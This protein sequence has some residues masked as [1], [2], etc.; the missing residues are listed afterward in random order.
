MAPNSTDGSFRPNA[1]Y[2]AMIV[3]NADMMMLPL[4]NPPLAWR[5]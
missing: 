3:S 5:C 1:A 2:A 4:E